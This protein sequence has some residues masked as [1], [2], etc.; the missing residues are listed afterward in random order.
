ME[1]F[2]TDARPRGAPCGQSVVLVVY[3]L[4]IYCLVGSR[5]W[6]SGP[7]KLF[8][9][10][11]KYSRYEFTIQ[12]MSWAQMKSLGARN[13]ERRSAARRT[14]STCQGSSAWR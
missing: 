11:K 10:P 5:L 9:G 14:P 6:D 12:H 1:R 3:Y 2:V 13:R 4:Q 8:L 7:P